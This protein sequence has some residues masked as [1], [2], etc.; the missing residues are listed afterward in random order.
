MATSATVGDGSV[1]AAE[2][3][4]HPLVPAA[5]LTLAALRFAPRRPDHGALEPGLLSSASFP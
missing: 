3:L 4:E 2:S 5:R 1:V